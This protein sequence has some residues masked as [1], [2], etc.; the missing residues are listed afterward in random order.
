[1]PHVFSLQAIG[2]SMKIRIDIPSFHGSM[3]NEAPSI[4][5]SKHSAVADLNLDHLWIVHLGPHSYPVSDSISV[6][7]LHDVTS[8]PGQLDNIPS[9]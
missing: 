7:A 6:L 1:M 4:T 2:K 5:R 3:F 9:V 8:L